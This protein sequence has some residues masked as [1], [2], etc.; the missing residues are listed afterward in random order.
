MVANLTQSRRQYIYQLEHWGI[1]KYNVAHTNIF[2]SSGASSNKRKHSVAASEHADGYHSTSSSQ[3]S[4]SHKRPMVEQRTIGP[5]EDAGGQQAVTDYHERGS[6]VPAETN[7]ATDNSVSQP[8][9]KPDPMGLGVIFTA[10]GDLCWF[11]SS[12]RDDWY[13]SRENLK[14]SHKVSL[15]ARQVRSRSYETRENVD[16]FRRYWVYLQ[17]IG[18]YL[19]G[20]RRFE[21]A[22]DIYALML[23]SSNQDTCVTALLSC[24]RSA[25]TFQACLWLE[26]FLQEEPPT[27]KAPFMTWAALVRS[28]QERTPIKEAHLQTWD[29]LILA[30]LIIAR[31]LSGR[32]KFRG[33]RCA[34]NALR[35]RR[36]ANCFFSGRPAAS[37]T[38][39]Q[40]VQDWYFFE[41]G[42]E[43][44]LDTGASG[45][46]PELLWDHHSWKYSQLAMEM[47]LL[48]S[49]LLDF[50]NL[51]MART[52]D[53]VS[54]R[55]P[56]DSSSVILFKFL[57]S[58]G[59]VSPQEFRG[60]APSHWSTPESFR[61]SAPSHWSAWAETTRALGATIPHFTGAC[62][63]LLTYLVS[64][65]TNTSSVT[66]DNFHDVDL[67]ELVSDM[68]AH[69]LYWEFLRVY[70]V[71]DSGSYSR[72]M[73]GFMEWGCHQYSV[74]HDRIYGVTI[75]PPRHP[76]FYR[77]FLRIA[78]MSSTVAD[79]ADDHSSSGVAVSTSSQFSEPLRGS[80]G[81][82]YHDPT[83]V[84]SCGSS[85]ASYK[86]IIKARAAMRRN[87]KEVGEDRPTSSAS[88]NLPSAAMDMDR[89]SISMRSLSMR[90]LSMRSRSV[91]SPS[92]FSARER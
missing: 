63:D 47:S 54:S 79:V 61:W 46:R 6:S 13:A 87:L 62:C 80:L 24:A 56:D 7:D 15:S 57:W 4:S 59:F 44:N 71:R 40:E 20:I 35:L 2:G 21:E 92:L 25:N 67:V 53:D 65:H 37:W 75:P 8:A 82:L 74:Q 72:P 68:D 86:A 83:W 26:S 84:S 51:I 43:Y 52:L 10:F 1:T 16:E 81:T 88:A 23:E 66:I 55:N 33:R 85:L 9:T 27:K 73:S 91:R 58:R 5:G 64:K 38:T 11:L 41:L 18:D 70:C 78:N 29:T 30:H 76:E 32:C 45:L 34:E 39:M 14:I 19:W 77:L 36:K 42:E 31:K 90:S 49:L 89:L 60:S 28:L 22:Y 69:R 3:A 48:R 50:C 12:S 17:D